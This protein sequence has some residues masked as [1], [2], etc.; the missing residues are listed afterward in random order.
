MSKMSKQ[1]ETFTIGMVTGAILVIL[2]S[3]LSG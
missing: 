2:L 3:S 1:V